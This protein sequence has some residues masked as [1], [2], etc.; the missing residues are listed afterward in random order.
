MIEPWQAEKIRNALQPKAHRPRSFGTPIEYTK[1]QAAS[2]AAS[3]TSGAFSRRRHSRWAATVPAAGPSQ[4]TLPVR[5]GHS[6][7]IEF[8]SIQSS[9]AP[10]R[11]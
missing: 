6:E 2:A 5:P 7:I 11:T 8:A 9:A 4:Q 10:S 1:I 3:A